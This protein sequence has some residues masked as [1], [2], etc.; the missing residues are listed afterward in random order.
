MA[1]KYT[2]YN[3]ILKPVKCTIFIY[4]AGKC[5]LHLL[6]SWMTPFSNQLCD[7]V[8]QT[9]GSKSTVVSAT[10]HSSHFSHCWHHSETK[11]RR[12]KLSEPARSQAAK[13]KREG[14]RGAPLQSHCVLSA[15]LNPENQTHLKGKGLKSHSKQSCPLFLLIRLEGIKNQLLETHKNVIIS[16]PLKQQCIKKLGKYAF[17]LQSGCNKFPSFHCWRWKRKMFHEHCC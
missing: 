16:L 8:R 2:W 17:M 14:G 15:V 7:D 5:C 10:G 11:S 3:C 1:V 9:S 4:K 13:I 12:T 6:L